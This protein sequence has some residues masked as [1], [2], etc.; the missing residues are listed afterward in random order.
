MRSA[1]SR[2]TYTSISILRGFWVGLLST[3]SF[4]SL[5]KQLGYSEAEVFTGSGWCFVSV[6][7]LWDV[8]FVDMMTDLKKNLVQVF[9]WKSARLLTPHPPLPLSPPAPSFFITKQDWLNRISPLQEK[10]NLGLAI[11]L[12][13]SGDT[14]V[15]H[16]TGVYLLSRNPSVNSFSR[17]I[18]VKPD[19]RRR[20]R[21]KLWKEPR[22]SIRRGRRF[23]NWPTMPV[24][25]TVVVN[26][27]MCVFFW[28]V[29]G[30]PR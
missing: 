25:I 6:S 2:C 18:D 22:N 12:W 4:L 17:E 24:L 5:V 7:I 26:R 27:K 10:K 19:R 1:Y 8:L 13:C 16:W 15:F 20:G 30:S 29:D 9:V 11:F 3:K 14:C 23:N 21:R 28:L